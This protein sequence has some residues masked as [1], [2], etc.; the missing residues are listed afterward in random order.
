MYFYERRDK[1]EKTGKWEKR[2]KTEKWGKTKKNGEKTTKMIKTQKNT[3]SLVKHS[4]FPRL[5]NSWPNGV[6]TSNL[7]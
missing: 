2:E 6:Y 3:S 4:V 1:S 7:W 5:G